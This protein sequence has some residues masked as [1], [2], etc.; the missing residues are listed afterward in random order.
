[1]RRRVVARGIKE[2]AAERTMS[3]EWQKSVPAACKLQ[4]NNNANLNTVYMDV[5]FFFAY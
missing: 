1:M 3:P 4:H 2:A 5:F